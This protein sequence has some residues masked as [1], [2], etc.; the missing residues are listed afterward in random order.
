[1]ENQ[2]K[3][4]QLIS[5][6]HVGKNRCVE[7]RKQPD[8]SHARMPNP[9]EPLLLLKISDV[10]DPHEEHFAKLGVV[11]TASQ[12]KYQAFEVLYN[13]KHLSLLMQIDNKKQIDDMFILLEAYPEYEMERTERVK[14]ALFDLDYLMTKYHMRDKV[15]EVRVIDEDEDKK[16]TDTKG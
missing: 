11:V 5:L 16:E 8:V 13:D 4:G 12:V 6:T 10:Y 9:G 2:F 14:Q 3:P 1:M 7:H 15:A